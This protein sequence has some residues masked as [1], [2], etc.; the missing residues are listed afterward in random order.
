MTAAA[1]AHAFVA[2]WIVRFGVP[3]TITTDRRRQFESRLFADPMKTLGIIRVRTTAYHPAANGMVER[4]Q[5]QLKTS[6]R[7]HHSHRWTETLPMVLL[8]I[9]SALKT[10]LQCSSAELVEGATLRLPGEFLQSSSPRRCTGLPD[11]QQYAEALCNTMTKLRP[12]LHR[13]PPATHVFVSQDLKTCTHVFVRR[14]TLR[15]PP[16]PRYD[17]PYLVVKRNIK[18]YVVDVGRRHDIIAI[19]RLK[20]AYIEDPPPL[21]TVTSSA[22]LHHPVLSAAPG[23]STCTGQPTW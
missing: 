19:D 4:F 10:D 2:G 12:V 15:K 18:A 6:L 21:A 5:R 7:A 22:P 9:R 11:A 20:P 14:D 16:D 3:T 23:D 13:T 8:G 1:V 17:G